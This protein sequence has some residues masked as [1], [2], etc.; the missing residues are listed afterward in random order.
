MQSDNQA[1]L[2]TVQRTGLRCRLRAATGSVE[3]R[4]PLN[5]V[6]PMD[7]VAVTPTAEGRQPPGH[8]PRTSDVGP[9]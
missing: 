2:P 9:V 1:L 3:V 4:I 6:P 7:L 5:D 8:V